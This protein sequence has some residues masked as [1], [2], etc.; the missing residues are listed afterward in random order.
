[1]KGASPLLLLPQ[2]DYIK[3]MMP[4]YMHSVCLGVVRHFTGLLFSSESVG[5]PYHIT[6]T[7]MAEIDEILTALKVP[8]EVRRSPRGLRERVHWKAFE[9]RAFITLYAPVVLVDF[10]PPQYMKHW[11]LLSS[12]I[13]IL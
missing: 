7:R 1:M 10:L 5:S 6:A 9:W 2:F 4:E 3:G 8:N 12:S 11:L 13:N